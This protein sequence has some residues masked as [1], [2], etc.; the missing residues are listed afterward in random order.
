M[1][2]RE[3]PVALA[4][5]LEGGGW[6]AVPAPEAQQAG[7][8]ISRVKEPLLYGIVCCTAHQQGLPRE[9]VQRIQGTI[10]GILQQCMWRSATLDRLA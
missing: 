8:A 6:G 3:E 4:I 5:E 1:T 10:M 9:E 7:C 2:C